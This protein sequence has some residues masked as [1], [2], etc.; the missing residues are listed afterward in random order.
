[1]MIESWMR[2]FAQFGYWWLV[3]LGAFAALAVAPDS[4]AQAAAAE[5]WAIEEL[6]VTARKREENI[7]DVGLSVSAMG[8]SE[9]A[10]NFAR[11]IRDLVQ[12]SP[13]L[14][15]DDTAQGPGGVASAYIRG[16][17]V[18][19]VEKNFDPAV[20]VVVD[21]VFLGAMSGSITRA[22]D[23]ER[24][25]VLR[26]P[27]GTLF[28][29]NTIGG[30]INLERSKPTGEFGAKFRASVGNY[31]TTKIDALVN[32]GVTEQ[33]AIKLTG[34]FDDQGEGYYD[35]INT[36][37]DEG[38][39]EY[40]S[41]GF[42]ALYTVD[43][44]LEFEY[45]YQRERTDQDTPPLLY[46][47]QPGQLF[48]DGFGFC[49][50]DLD[51]P[52]SGDRWKTAQDLVGPDDATFDA[53]THI[54][55]AHWDINENWTMDYIFGSWETEETVLTD[56][57]AVPSLLFHTSRPAEYEQ[58]SHELRFT[59]DGGGALSGTVGL[60]LWESEY[61]IRLR[62]FIGFAGPGVADL[63]QTSAQETDSQ[64]LFFEADYRL[65][66][67]LT[68]TLGGRYTR[69]EK[70]TAQSGIVTAVA[71]DDWTEFTPKVGARYQLTDDAMVYLTYS[72]GYR[73]GGFNGR[74][75]SVLTATQPYNQ[76]TV[77]NIELGFKTEWLDRRLRLN[78]A[79]FRMDY[80]DKQEELQLPSATSGTGQVTL[81]TNASTAT[82][83]GIELD[84][85]YMPAP[86]L[87]IRANLGILD[88]EYDDFSFTGPAGPVD[89]SD[90]EFRRAPE[91]T[92][93]LSGT[94]EW[95]VGEGRAWIHAGVQ[96]LDE[97]E[98]DFANKPELTN[99]SQNIVNASVN[100]AIGSFQI[101][102]YGHN[103][104]EEDGYG[105]GFDVAGLWS[106]AATRAPRTYALEIAY[107]LE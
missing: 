77:D 53:D 11:D 56:F 7:Q 3:I 14:V 8:P 32:F 88:A 5:D 34:T 92:A 38:R 13:N 100:Y 90:L 89:F 29:R 6:V 30:V 12:V 105:I 80:D 85:L 66:D 98:V 42:N 96:Y 106:Y 33:L 15:L 52:I 4:R 91:V 94:Y 72:V 16:V 9:I 45:T 70:D 71:D 78:G 59:Y 54:L 102:A 103:L 35:N 20:G 63:P 68:F 62:S 61:E 67:A 28:G 19:E 37:R 46:V 101:S 65:N 55:E 81:V 107:T 44:T 74:V 93:S 104:T 86:G 83:Q 79:I 48:C 64:A 82:M 58:S 51:T 41:L 24:V 40:Q 1:M 2:A 69:D 49:A 27:Q 18:S 99:D 10:D 87:S 97:Y 17:G 73:S 26:G 31:E 25:E 57:D 36:G 43:D 95:S 75:D 23:L 47:G 21:G 50:P 76:E 39:V 84:A 22:L 60:Y